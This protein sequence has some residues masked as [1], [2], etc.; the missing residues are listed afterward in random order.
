MDTTSKLSL[1]KARA[2]LTRV[3]ATWAVLRTHLTLPTHAKVF[4]ALGTVPAHVKAGLVQEIENTEAA[5]DLL[6]QAL[7]SARIPDLQRAI[8][9]AFARMM[10]GFP[11]PAL[12]PLLCKTVATFSSRTAQGKLLH[13]HFDRAKAMADAILT[14]L[15][16]AGSALEAK[17][18]SS[19]TRLLS[20]KLA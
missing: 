19:P 18:H 11:T 8:Y 14:D 3:L 2:I 5:F 13:L 12:Q 9:A 20:L 16:S 6:G 10:E 4:T 15:L 17:P 7:R 1:D